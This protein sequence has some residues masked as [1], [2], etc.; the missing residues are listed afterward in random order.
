MSAIDVDVLLRPIRDDA[1][2][3][4]D[5]SGER[6]Y[7]ALEQM[8]AGTQER[9]IGETIVAAQ[10]PDWRDIHKQCATLLGRSRDLRLMVYLTLAALRLDGL[11]GLRDGLAL[12]KSHIAQN[13]DHLWPRL[14]PDDDLDPLERMNILQ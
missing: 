10:D 2:C 7:S 13:W 12:L 5:V 8:L 11:N 9:Q 6:D 14:D 4:D 3:G 1:P